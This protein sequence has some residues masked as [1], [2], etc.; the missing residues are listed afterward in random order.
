MKKIK[1]WF[2]K[3]LNLLF[4]NMYKRYETEQ[5][6]KLKSDKKGPVTKKK[7]IKQILVDINKNKN[8]LEKIFCIKNC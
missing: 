5:I 7:G 3:T 4:I 6:V 2:L 1:N 8:F